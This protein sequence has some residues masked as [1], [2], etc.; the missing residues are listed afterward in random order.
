[1]TRA[2]SFIITM[3]TM[4]VLLD[5]QLALPSGGKGKVIQNRKEY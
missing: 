4:A 2:C 3:I 1:V 5:V